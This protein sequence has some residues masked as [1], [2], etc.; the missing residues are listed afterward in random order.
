[1]STSAPS[2]GNVNANLLTVMQSLSDAVNGLKQEVGQS[3][4]IASTSSQGAPDPLWGTGYTANPDA[5]ANANALIAQQQAQQQLSQRNN[6]DPGTSAGAGTGTPQEDQESQAIR[7]LTW[8]SL[9]NMGGPLGSFMQNRYVAQQ[10]QGAISSLASK[11]AGAGPSQPVMTINPETGELEQD[12][13]PDGTPKVTGGSAFGNTALGGAWNAGMNKLSNTVGNNSLVTGGLMTATQALDTGSTWAGIGQ[14]LGYG[15]RIGLYGAAARQEGSLAQAVSQGAD[16]R[17]GVND[18][19][20]QGMPLDYAR[21]DVTAVTQAGFSDTGLGRGDNTTIAS[22]L[23][24]PLTQQ[25]VSAQGATE[26]A[27]ALRNAGT[28]VQSLTTSLQGMATAAQ[29]TKETT[30]QFNSSLLEFA[31]SQV[32]NGG[33]QGQAAQTGMDFTAATGM[34]PSILGQLQSNPMYQGLMMGENSVLPSDIGNL[35]PGA[36]LE[37]VRNLMGLLGSGFRG[38]DKNKYETVNGVRMVSSY[39]N[40]AQIAQMAQMLNITQTQAHRLYNEVSGGHFSNVENALNTIGNPSAEY[41]QGSMLYS[42]LNKSKTWQGLSESEREKATRVWDGINIHGLGL[43]EKQINAIQDTSNIRKRANLLRTDLLVNQKNN[44]MN[45]ITGSLKVYV[46][47]SHHA[48]RLINVTT[49]KALVQMNARAGG[50]A[51]NSSLNSTLGDAWS[52]SDYGFSTH[53]G[54]DPIQEETYTPS[55]DN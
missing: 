55:S 10:Y 28:N 37:G 1:M 48:K 18:L 38:L 13:N 52:A 30:D 16:I 14:A 33:T 35:A 9:G 17:T 27:D 51:A 15:H 43:H 8:E 19:Y 2:P 24:A 31:Q 36:Q 40:Q 39:G 49:G 25:G 29:A 5:A 53:T 44:P 21:Q 50:D 23:V 6:T 4:Q 20:R 3:R 12:T 11:V 32:A 7:A 47:V 34:A 42:I 41:G 46:D 26:W 22:N 45:K 54:I